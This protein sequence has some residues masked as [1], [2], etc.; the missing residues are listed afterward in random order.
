MRRFRRRG[1]VHAA[2]ELQ[3]ALPHDLRARFPA[4]HKSGPDRPPGERGDD[5]LAGPG[6]VRGAR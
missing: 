4:Y 3:S 1:D 6:A 2:L 5:R